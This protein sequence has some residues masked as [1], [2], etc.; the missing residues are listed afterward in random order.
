[1]PKNIRSVVIGKMLMVQHIMLHG[2]GVG[3]MNVVVT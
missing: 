3:L 2:K 1:M